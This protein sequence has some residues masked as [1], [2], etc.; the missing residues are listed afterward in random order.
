MSPGVEC[1]AMDELK[2]SIEVARRQDNHRLL[3][4]QL[5][6]KVEGGSTFAEQSTEP[7][8]FQWNMD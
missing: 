5:G 1:G 8:L 7:R 4:V 2:C 6:V 3:K